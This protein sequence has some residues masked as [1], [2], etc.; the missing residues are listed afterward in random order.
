MP[1]VVERKWNMVPKAMMIRI[2][3]NSVRSA[4]AD[5]A[6]ANLARLVSERGEAYAGLSRLLGRKPDYLSRYVRKGT[7][8][9]DAEE[10]LCLARYFRVAP[11]LFGAPVEEPPERTFAEP[12]HLRDDELR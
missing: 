11:Q 7:P 1:L 9:L 4:N 6:R 8:Q 2:D 10:V 12:K 5:Q 3:P